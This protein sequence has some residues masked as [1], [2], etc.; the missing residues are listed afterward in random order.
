MVSQLLCTG[1]YAVQLSKRGSMKKTFSLATL[2]TKTVVKISFWRRPTHRDCFRYVTREKQQSNT[3]SHLTTCLW[4]RMGWHK[5]IAALREWCIRPHYVI[6]AIS[7]HSDAFWVTFICNSHFYKTL[8]QVPYSDSSCI[9]RTCGI[10][11]NFGS[12]RVFATIF[13]AKP[14]ILLIRQTTDNLSQ[15]KRV[16]KSNHDIFLDSSNLYCQQQNFGIDTTVAQQRQ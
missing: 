10:S 8:T 3:Y 14:K 7:K 5:E 9:L 1:Q 13:W 15:C 16:L 12:S 6:Q 2:C 11:W 4:N